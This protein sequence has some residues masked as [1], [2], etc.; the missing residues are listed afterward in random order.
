MG[1]MN[2]KL[3]VR[4]LRGILSQPFEPEAVKTAVGKP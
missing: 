4:S 2:I 3:G 1:K